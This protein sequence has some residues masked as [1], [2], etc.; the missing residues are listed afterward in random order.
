MKKKTTKKKSTAK[1]LTSGQLKKIRGGTCTAS[2]PT[3]KCSDVGARASIP[4][5]GSW[6]TWK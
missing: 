2:S 5:C 1:K 6:L 4:N 3:K